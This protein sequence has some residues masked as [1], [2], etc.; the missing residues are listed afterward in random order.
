M[1]M[2]VI[3]YVRD[4]HERSTRRQS[5]FYVY[6]YESKYGAADFYRRGSIKYNELGDYLR[7]IRTITI[8]KKRHREKLYA[9][10][11]VG[12]RNNEKKLNFVLDKRSIPRTTKLPHSHGL[13]QWPCPKA[14]TAKSMR[15]LL[16]C[17]LASLATLKSK[18]FWLKRLFKLRF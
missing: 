17:D 10:F 4:I 12:S 5:D 9:D 2:S 6:P 8:F 11:V 14:P 13:D 16:D 7:R 15:M 3:H 1:N 18:I